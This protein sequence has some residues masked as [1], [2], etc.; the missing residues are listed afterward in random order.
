LSPI[1]IR[2]ISIF[3]V[4]VMPVSPGYHC[5][6]TEMTENRFS[7]TGT[8]DENPDPAAKRQTLK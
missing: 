1:H 4:P 2:L 7:R 6:Q 5:R 8:A 3:P